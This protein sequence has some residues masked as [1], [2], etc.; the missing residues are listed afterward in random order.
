MLVFLTFLGASK[1]NIGR[2]SVNLKLLNHVEWIQNLLVD[3]LKL[4]LL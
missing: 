1:G 4:S 3:L 2:K